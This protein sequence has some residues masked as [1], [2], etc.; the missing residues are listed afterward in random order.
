[1]LVRLD[2]AS[3]APNLPIARAS[4]KGERS[5]LTP[6]LTASGLARLYAGTYY[7]FRS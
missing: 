3:A 1:M 6:P 2:P 7:L 5:S 4:G